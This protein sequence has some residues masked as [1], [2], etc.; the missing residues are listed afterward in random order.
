MSYRWTSILSS[1]ATATRKLISEAADAEAT[2]DRP[3]VYTVELEVRDPAGATSISSVPVI[4]GNSRPMVE[5]LQPQNGDFFTPGQPVRYQLLVRDQEDGTSDFDEA[6]Q[7]NWHLIESQAPSRLFVEAIPETNAGSSE[8]DHPGLALIRKSDCLNCH[9][10][11]RKLVGPSFVEIAD[12]YRDQ[13]H[14]L[15]QSVA[16]VREGS[17]GV[18]GKIGML[19]HQ[20]HTESEVT[21]MVE[22]VFATTAAATHPS[23][24]GFNNEILIG[25][26]GGNLRLEAAYTDLGRGEIPKLVGIGSVVLRNRSVQAEAADEIQGTQRLGSDQAE[27]KY[28]MGAINH[29]AFLK[30]NNLPLDEL[31]SITVRVT[32]AGAGGDI[33]VRRGG[34]DGELLGSIT[35]E[36]NGS[37]SDFY[38]KTIDLKPQS[39]R[40]A[41]YLVFKNPANRGGLMNI[42]SLT[43]Q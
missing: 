27:G 23:A 11:S 22:Y 32:S 9:A 20:Q 37:W 43:F 28:S 15:E 40:D 21:Q 34:M 19:P 13:P 6:E 1:D 17:T 42:D 8:N 4:V 7:E 25:D 18:W 3:G 2:F 5:F 38:S 14:Q 12:K 26:V 29:G 36:I 24:Q 39:G 16:R 10:A 33:E 41:I 35:V 31:R 30:F